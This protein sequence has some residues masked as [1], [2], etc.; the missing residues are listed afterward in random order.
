M[1]YER[2]KI[3]RSL[4]FLVVIIMAEISVCFASRTPLYNNVNLDEVV[5]NYNKIIVDYYDNAVGIKGL[6]DIYV[7]KNKK[8]VGGDANGSLYSYGLGGRNNQLVR[9]LTNEKEEVLSIEVAL[10][11][12]SPI[13]KYLA[14]SRNSRYV[15]DLIS[16]LLIAS[17]AIGDMPEADVEQ[18]IDEL[19][20]FGY[21]TREKVRMEFTCNN[22]KYWVEK[23]FDDR[24]R[25]VKVEVFVE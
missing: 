20:H 9:F 16:H 13:M 17:F 18:I 15:G 14:A 7:A 19:N 12:Q 11:V 21:L 22:R 23:Y 3:F 6:S 2:T 1:K 4:I 10:H 25:A 5:N 8:K 24:L